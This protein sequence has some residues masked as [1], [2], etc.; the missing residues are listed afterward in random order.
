MQGAVDEPPGIS[1]TKRAHPHEPGS[2]AK[3]T[4]EGRAVCNAPGIPTEAPAAGP[5]QEGRGVRGKVSSGRQAAGSPG[6]TVLGA[7]EDG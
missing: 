7:Q 5:G 4:T 3:R 6:P 2:P 1:R